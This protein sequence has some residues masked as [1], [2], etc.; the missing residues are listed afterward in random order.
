[1]SNQ[2]TSVISQSILKRFETAVPA[3][4]QTEINKLRTS[5]I[6]NVKSVIQDFSNPKAYSYYSNVAREQLFNQKINALE[7]SLKNDLN[8]V[9]PPNVAIDDST[10]KSE[11]PVREQRVIQVISKSTELT[12]LNAQLEQYKTQIAQLTRQYKN[13]EEEHTILSNEIAKLRKNQQPLDEQIKE[14][15]A[16]IKQLEAD[17]NEKKH[18]LEKVQKELKEMSARYVELTQQIQKNEDELNMIIDSTLDIY[19]TI[20]LDVNAQANLSDKFRV[21]INK[22]NE[23]IQKNTDR[24]VIYN[25]ELSKI[26]D[27]INKINK[28]INSTN[29]SAAFASNANE[30]LLKTQFDQYNKILSDINTY[31]EENK[32]LKKTKEAAEGELRVL[33]E[34][35][36]QLAGINTTLTATNAQLNKSIQSQEAE[37]QKQRQTNESLARDLDSKKTELNLLKASA[38]DKEHLINDRIKQLEKQVEELTQQ[39][40]DYAN[41]YTQLKTNLDKIKQQYLQIQKHLQEATAAKSTTEK[42]PSDIATLQAELESLKSQSVQDLASKKEALALQE[43]KIKQLM[44]QQQEYNTEITKLKSDMSNMQSTLNQKE[45]QIQAQN[46][47]ITSLRQDIATKQKAIEDQRKQYEIRFQQLAAEKL[48]NNKKYE[49]QIKIL[50]NTLILMREKMAIIQANL[51][52]GLIGAEK[53]VKSSE[54]P[55]SVQQLTMTEAEEYKILKSNVVSLLGLILSKKVQPDPASIQDAFGEAEKRIAQQLKTIERQDKIIQSINKNIV[56]IVQVVANNPDLKLDVTNVAN[57]DFDKNYQKFNDG[58]EQVNSTFNEIAKHSLGK[59]MINSASKECQR[60]LENKSGEMKEV[61]NE[62]EIKVLGRGVNKNVDALNQSISEYNRL[63][64]AGREKDK[65]MKELLTPLYNKHQVGGEE[66]AIRMVDKHTAKYGSASDGTESGP[67]MG[68]AAITTESKDNDEQFIAEILS[69]GDSLIQQSQSLHGNMSTNSNEIERLH[70]ESTRVNAELKQLQSEHSALKTRL[71]A[72]TVDTEQQKKQLNETV[73]N[74]QTDIDNLRRQQSDLEVK[75]S[76]NIKTAELQT[77]K[78]KKAVEE[79]GQTQKQL[80]ETNAT[81]AAQLEQIRGLSSQLEDK[82]QELTQKIADL[83]SKSKECAENIAKCNTQYE[84]WRTTEQAQMEQRHKQQY[85][86]QSQQIVKLK[87]ENTT[88]QERFEA[89][90]KQK[91]EAL[92]ALRTT[93]ETQTAELNQ[94]LETSNKELADLR[95]THES[96]AKQLTELQ[97]Q[98]KSLSA[99]KETELQKSAGL[100]EQIKQLQQKIADLNAAK[101][102]MA[103]ER[104]QLSGQS[105]QEA[106]QTQAKL[107]DLNK[108]LTQLTQLKDAAIQKSE[109]QAQ[110]IADLEQDAA[111]L[112][113]TNTQIAEEKQRLA[114]EKERL[115]EEKNKLSG[116]SREKVEQTEKQLAELKTANAKFKEDMGILT[117]QKNKMEA[118]LKTL[119]GKQQILTAERDKLSQEKTSLQSQLNASGQSNTTLNQQLEIVHK[120]LEECAINLSKCDENTKQMQKKLDEQEL[121]VIKTKIN[122]LNKLMLIKQTETVG[123]KNKV[124]TLFEQTKSYFN[125]KNTIGETEPKYQNFQTDSNIMSKNYKQIETNKST[126]DESIAIINS[127][128]SLDVAL[129]SK[130]EATGILQTAKNNYNTINTSYEQLSKSMSVMEGIALQMRDLLERM[131]REQAEAERKRKEE[132]KRKQE[133][134][135]AER[136]KQLVLEEARADKISK[137]IE[138]YK[139]MFK[140]HN[141]LEKFYK[142]WTQ[143][144]PVDST[145]DSTLSSIN[146]SINAGLLNDNYNYKQEYNLLEKYADFSAPG[147]ASTSPF[148]TAHQKANVVFNALTHFKNIIVINNPD[149][150]L[151]LALKDISSDDSNKIPILKLKWLFSHNSV[152]PSTEQELL[153]IAPEKFVKNKMRDIFEAALGSVIVFVK[154]RTGGGTETPSLVKI[155][156]IE[157]ESVIELQ[158]GDDRYVNF[159]EHCFNGIIPPEFTY[160][161]NA[162][163]NP[164]QQQLDNMALYSSME[165]TLNAVHNGYNLFLSGAGYSGAGKS[166]TLIEDDSSLLITFIKKNIESFDDAEFIAFEQYGYMQITDDT[167]LGKIFAHDTSNIR[168]HND[169]ISYFYDAK[170]KLGEIKYSKFTNANLDNTFKNI[171]CKKENTNTDDFIAKIKKILIDIKAF[172]IFSNRIR[173]TINNHESSRG[174]V[175]YVL[176]LK[177]GTQISYM[178]VNDMGGQESPREILTDYMVSETSKTAADDRR[179][180]YFKYLYDTYGQM[181]KELHMSYKSSAAP[182]SQKTSKKQTP[183]KTSSP[184]KQKILTS[185][186]SVEPAIPKLSLVKIKKIV[187]WF[188]TAKN[189]LYEN[190]LSE[191]SKDLLNSDK[192][193]IFKWMGLTFYDP[194]CVTIALYLYGTD[195]YLMS[196]VIP[197]MEQS[198]NDINI[199]L[200]KKILVASEFKESNNKQKFKD[201]MNDLKNTLQAYPNSLNVLYAENVERKQLTKQDAYAKGV[202]GIV[203]ILNTPVPDKKGKKKAV[204]IQPDINDLFLTFLEGFYI[205]DTLMGKARYLKEIQ[206]LLSFNESEKLY[207]GEYKYYPI[208]DNNFNMFSMMFESNETKFGSTQITNV[209]QYL[210]QINQNKPMR[211]IEIDAIRG[212]RDEKKDP[213]K[214]AL[215]SVITAN[216]GQGFSSGQCEKSQSYSKTLQSSGKKSGLGEKYS[217]L[218]NPKFVKSAG[219][220]RE[221]NLQSANSEENSLEEIQERFDSDEQNSESDSIKNIDQVAGGCDCMAGGS[222]DLDRLSVSYSGASEDDS[223]LSPL[224]DYKD[225]NLNNLALGAIAGAAVGVSYAGLPG[226]LMLIGIVVTLIILYMLYVYVKKDMMPG[227]SAAAMPLSSTS[228]GFSMFGGSRKLW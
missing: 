70:Q 75:L 37:L 134:A 199:F 169:L 145:L 219:M 6:D 47:E 26:V 65:Q 217:G 35:N 81:N 218:Y 90:I 111:K 25:S 144:T 193:L 51:P 108:Q 154:L 74:K 206:S 4:V 171:L 63:Y 198:S 175:Y 137:Y 189:P 150:Y 172:R 161:P 125:A 104:A 151:T 102:Q 136:K 226:W 92:R 192:D 27:N 34:S 201:K 28:S 149:R 36:K 101:E 21:L 87:T 174:H 196:S 188:K 94:R 30:E 77:E 142:E 68:T 127:I 73:A 31:V 103:Q 186:T 33:K 133:S 98:S 107:D 41:K 211:F 160:D 228:E 19:K 115:T 195:Q 113:A 29:P 117:E 178:I 3:N 85:D 163:I 210:T 72:N 84:Q 224:F 124:I 44:T 153:D 5:Y 165:A 220:S 60:Y 116:Q 109:T 67:G 221:D 80:A 121:E 69:M 62:G 158:I 61:T 24:I 22:L 79:L 13:L 56:P 182:S 110:R 183:S 99:Q 215:A 185:Q 176:K 126:A 119:E 12:E 209:Y 15:D 140:T 45:G 146:T 7:A 23:L 11:L 191:T 135:E 138:M 39:K 8:K 132:E 139:L 131:K 58:A 214:F 76:T 156:K 122:N 180:N 10:T 32:H 204:I 205:N 170:N 166:A 95:V 148:R 48:A 120:Q 42:K 14:K 130:T 212:H 123:L 97:E 184:Q 52:S 147:N 54:L 187:D 83:A 18:E 50:R 216:S 105:Q 157:N 86:E 223:V 141:K 106:T 2:V 181:T 114:E 64:V 93:T 100:A 159:Y 227:Y 88:L 164:D 152:F 49:E 9:I 71:E 167:T 55:L 82:K 143:K 177:K 96:N 89:Q 20:A 46:A 16:K 91:E 168:F 197:S 194:L 202:E 213:Y 57:E 207:K 38:T 53:S 118:D 66:A 129:S 208:Y 59:C 155:S 225:P 200:D 162:E 173:P 40:N 78:A 203:E 222:T 17:L 112:K 190:A 128:K 179:N 43:Q 1:M